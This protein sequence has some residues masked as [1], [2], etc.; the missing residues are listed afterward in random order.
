MDVAEVLRKYTPE[1]THFRTV[2]SVRE[3]SLMLKEVADQPNGESLIVLDA[4]LARRSAAPTE[5]QRMF[6]VLFQDQDSFQ[7]RRIEC[8]L[9]DVPAPIASLEEPAIGLMLNSEAFYARTTTVLMRT[10]WYP[11][12]R[13]V[14]LYVMS[15]GGHPFVDVFA[16]LVRPYPT[17]DQVFAPLPSGD[18]PGGLPGIL[19]DVRQEISEEVDSLSNGNAALSRRY[20]KDYQFLYPLSFFFLCCQF[21]GVDWQSLQTRAPHVA[22][23]LEEYVASLCEL[24]QV[25]RDLGFTSQ[26]LSQETDIKKLLPE[27][28]D[29]W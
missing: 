16:L 21:N 18:A 28:S 19:D 2:R 25:L 10:N 14:G 23:I 24:K 11:F 4:M 7:H 12:A 13:A 5:M 17:L 15:H 20:D 9:T 26:I 1:A 3:Q 29:L 6:D 27:P 22:Q 8:L